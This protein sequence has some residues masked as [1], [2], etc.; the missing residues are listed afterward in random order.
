[1]KK[2]IKNMIKNVQ[3]MLSG[4]EVIIVDTDGQLYYHRA[5]N[6]KDAVEWLECYPKADKAR[7]WHFGYMIAVR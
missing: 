5:A 3:Y 4:L 6:W 2:I 1:M 7:V